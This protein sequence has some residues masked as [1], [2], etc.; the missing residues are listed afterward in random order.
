LPELLLPRRGW[1]IDE[2]LGYT[3]QEQFKGFINCSTMLRFKDEK[4]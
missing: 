4:T 2:P 3:V 1:I